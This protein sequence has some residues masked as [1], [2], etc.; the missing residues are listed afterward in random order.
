MVFEFI[1]KES[2]YIYSMTLYALSR[3]S[4]TI[5]FIRKGCY[6]LYFWALTW[7]TKQL[8]L[9]AVKF[10]KVR[11]KDMECK[12]NLRA[13]PKLEANVVHPGNCKQNVRLAKVI[14]DPSTIAAI[15]HYFPDITDSA[16][17]L[18]LVNT[19]WVISNS[20]GIFDD[21]IK[22]GNAAV[23]GDGRPQLFRS[24]ASWLENWK[25]QQISNAEKFTVTTNSP[26]ELGLGTHITISCSI[27]RGFTV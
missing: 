3:I 4:E 11:E 13:A 20:K 6:F 18:N 10:H 14:F 21:C 24:L 27:D 5:F 16:G 17:F 19:W 9:K 12:A 2:Q 23:R 8:R 26:N 1:L 25:S 7:G 15:K 22:L